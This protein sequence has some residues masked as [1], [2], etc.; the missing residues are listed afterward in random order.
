MA[1]K[2][3]LMRDVHQS[4]LD[5]RKGQ[6]ASPAGYAYKCRHVLI[7]ELARV[8]HALNDLNSGEFS[9]HDEGCT[10]PLQR[11][12]HAFEL[13]QLIVDARD[14]VGAVLVDLQRFDAFRTHGASGVL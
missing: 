11:R 7:A 8:H 9:Y 13:V 6:A 3:W 4:S 14:D 2:I 1:S 5:G 10:V 12:H